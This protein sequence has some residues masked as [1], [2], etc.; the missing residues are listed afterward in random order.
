MILPVASLPVSIADD[1]DDTGPLL[2]GANITP[3]QGA[4]EVEGGQ[5][6]ESPVVGAQSHA[7]EGGA[8]L[9]DAALSDDGDPA[10]ADEESDI[11]VPQASSAP[12]ASG[13]ALPSSGGGGGTAAPDTAGTTPIAV[14]SA[15]TTIAS[16]VDASAAPSTNNAVAFV[17]NGNDPNLDDPGDFGAARA[18]TKGK[19]L[20]AAS[21][22]SFLQQSTGT[23]TNFVTG[24]PDPGLLGPDATTVIDYNY[25]DTYFTFPAI[26]FNGTISPGTALT[27][28]R[29]G[30]T[31][32]G[33]EFQGEITYPTN[34]SD[35][36][37]HPL[38]ILLHGRHSSVYNPTNNATV[39]GWPPPAGDLRIPSFQGYEYMAPILASYGFIVDS[40]GADAINAFDANTTDDG[41]LARAQL[42]EDQLNLWNQLENTTTEP[43]AMAGS[44]NRASPACSRA[45]STCRMSA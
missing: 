3:V 15:E 8:E 5:V 28:T 27:T 25:G 31:L 13:G 1:L 37:S 26:S 33:A 6:P 34:L 19:S 30:S 44:P 20:S 24:V 39:G 38:I 29:G 43:T 12:A 9:W 22:S 17:A 40:I 32:Q 14:A 18:P 2:E 23:K 41:M 16:T 35:G 21:A 10:S 45:R 4:E 7:P 42:V 11:P 36:G